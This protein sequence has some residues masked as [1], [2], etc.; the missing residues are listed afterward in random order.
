MQGNARAT[1]LARGLER[2]VFRTLAGPA[3]R[4]VAA[5]RLS[6]RLRA[7]VRRLPQPCPTPVL[8]SRT[9]A[10]CPAPWASVRRALRHARCQAAKCRRPPDADDV[11]HRYPTTRSAL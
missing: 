5:A 7:S 6:P 2:R 1:S 9:T 11:E 3:I 10:A 4:T 8:H